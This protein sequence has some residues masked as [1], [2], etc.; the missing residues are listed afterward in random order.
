MGIS[1]ML[2]YFLVLELHT[3]LWHFGQEWCIRQKLFDLVDFS[4]SRMVAQLQDEGSD[5]DTKGL[6]VGKVNWGPLISRQLCL[7][8]GDNQYFS[9]CEHVLI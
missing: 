9:L 5:H 8:L 2:Q 3:D 6:Y 7:V 4:P 1:I